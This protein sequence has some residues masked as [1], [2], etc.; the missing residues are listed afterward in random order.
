MKWQGKRVL[1]TGGTG[2]VGSHLV[3]SLSEIGHQVFVPYLGYSPDDFFSIEQLHTRV[4]HTR[5][6]LCNYQELELYIQAN[7]IE[8]IFHLAAQPLVSVAYISPKTTLDNNILSTINVMEAARISP[9][10]SGVIVASSDKAYGVLEKEQYKETDPLNATHPY[11][12]SKAAT[13]MIA[14]SY[15]ATY[16][17]PTVTTRFGNIYGEGDLNFSRIIP[18]IMNSL[19]TGK[20]LIIR[21]NG[22]MKRDYL[23]VGDVVTGY[24]K[25]LE[26]FSKVEGEIFNFGSQ[27]TLT[28]LDV[29]NQAEQILNTRIKYQIADIAKSEIPYQSLNYDKA[30]KLLGWTP[31]TTLETSLKAIQ[32]YYQKIIKVN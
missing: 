32:E 27:E 25:I 2:F 9:A 31:E 18:G 13:E 12:V 16:H 23:Y 26:N 11:D 30:F 6:N 5:L 24:L 7:E 4:S 15:N 1:V 8:F 20:E 10:V 29:I 28:T 3:K 14:R 17:V 19:I 22:K 21:S